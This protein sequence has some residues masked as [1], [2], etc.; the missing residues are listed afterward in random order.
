MRAGSVVEDV[1]A[2]GAKERS[3]LKIRACGAK[4]RSGLK[5][6]ACGAK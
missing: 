3:G 4:E 5:I 1:R 2:C 6:R